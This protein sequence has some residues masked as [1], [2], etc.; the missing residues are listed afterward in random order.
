M[1]SA[2]NCSLLGFV[3][4]W[5]KEIS[6][7]VLFVYTYV[8]V[9]TKLSAGNPAITAACRAGDDHTASH[10]NTLQHAASRCIALHHT[11]SHCATL[12]NTASHYI[13]LHHTASHCITLHHTASHCDTQSHGNTLQQTTAQCNTQ[14]ETS[15]AAPRHI[16]R[17]RV[18][19][20]LSYPHTQVHPPQHSPL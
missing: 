1:S 12:R 17:F 13:T 18:H 19:L 6:F 20:L 11:A 3:C 10:C 4:K 2:K 5:G 8:S 7:E 14:Q 9:R 15:E 16:T